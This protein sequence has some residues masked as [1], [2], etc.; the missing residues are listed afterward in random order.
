MGSTTIRL[1]EAVYERLRAEKREDE[2]F[3]EAVERLLGRRSLLDLVGL[4]SPE[5]VEDVRRTLEGTDDDAVADV[6]ALL[7]RTER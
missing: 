2:T 5:A 4:W 1:D 3:S 7:E 6:D